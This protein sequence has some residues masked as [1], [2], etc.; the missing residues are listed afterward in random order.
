M[1]GSVSH[2]HPPLRTAHPP[3]LTITHSLSPQSPATN[4]SDGSSVLGL[5]GDASPRP[6]GLVRGAEDVTEDGEDNGLS[7]LAG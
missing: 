2:P 6:P 5:T 1:A 4:S 7:E 3:S